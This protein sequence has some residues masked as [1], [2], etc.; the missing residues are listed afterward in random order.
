MAGVTPVLYRLP[1][2][3]KAAASR[4]VVYIVEGRKTF[5]RWSQWTRCYTSR[6]ELKSGDQ[7]MQS[8]SLIP[9]MWSYFR[10]TT[11]RVGSMRSW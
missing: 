10:T 9:R 8:A 4:Q 3:L 1:E 11:N 7:N 5:T 2:V 6:W